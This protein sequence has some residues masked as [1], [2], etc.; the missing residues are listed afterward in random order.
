M[1]ILQVQLS[2][3]KYN[4]LLEYITKYEIPLDDDIQTNMRQ[5]I[6]ELLVDEALNNA[7]MDSSDFYEWIESKVA[8]KFKLK[9]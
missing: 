4:H 5:Y 3:T 2:D 8:A 1:K 9:K 7:N 6:F